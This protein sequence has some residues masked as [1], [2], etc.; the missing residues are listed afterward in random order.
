MGEEA[1]QGITRRDLLRR[2]AVLGGAVVWTTPMV[3]T[4]G[5]GRAFAQ[6]ASPIE[7]PAISYIALV[8]DCGDQHTHFIKWEVDENKWEHNPGRAPGCEGSL[9]SFDETGFGSH[10]EWAAPKKIN[11]RCYEL[12]IPSG[13]QIVDGVT[14]GSTDDCHD[15]A[16]SAGPTVRVGPGCP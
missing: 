16:P 4:L 13:C 2:G 9:I 8:I 10:D 5:M 15:I 12:T 6:T 1:S 7:G 11:D 3:Q 14:K